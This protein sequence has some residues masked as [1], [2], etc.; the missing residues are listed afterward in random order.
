MGAVVSLEGSVVESSEA[1]SSVAALSPARG[2]HQ[3]GEGDACR[4]SVLHVRVSLFDAPNVRESNHDPT[5]PMCESDE[6]TAGPV[7]RRFL[8]TIRLS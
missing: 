7:A 5:K 1:I 6:E 4:E 2:E 3:S 8:I